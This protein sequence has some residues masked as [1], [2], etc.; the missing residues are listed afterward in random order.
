MH[1]LSKKELKDI[2]KDIDKQIDQFLIDFGYKNCYQIHEK[3]KFNRPK[4]I[5]QRFIHP[6]SGRIYRYQDVAIIM[7]DFPDNNDAIFHK[8]TLCWS[9]KF[10]ELLKKEGCKVEEDDVFAYEYFTRCDRK[11]PDYL[12]LE[13]TIEPRPIEWDDLTDDLKEHTYWKERFNK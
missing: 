4:E 12:K 7:N 8:N 2:N 6:I 9:K 13:F 10:D 5:W 3:N 1:D 11:D